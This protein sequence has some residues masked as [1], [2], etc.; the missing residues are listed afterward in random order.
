MRG[1][2][3]SGLRLRTGATAAFLVVVAS[4]TWLPA[5]ASA[6]R[7]YH[8]QHL[9]LT[10]VGNAPLRSGFV[11]NIKA[12]GPTVY[13]HE[14]FV[15]NGASSDT[16]YT[17][18]RSFFYLQPDCSGDGP[19]FMDEVAVLQTNAAGNARGDVLVRPADVA[20]AE[21]VSGVFWSVAD[22]AGTVV[23][24]TACTAVTLD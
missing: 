8:S 24:Q 5:L 17:V 16:T 14:V 2:S 13:A 7:V 10:P 20:G 18:T 6:D 9:D 21:G 22:E 11:E 3:Y 19:V 12:E 1:F 23:S 4:V 15:L